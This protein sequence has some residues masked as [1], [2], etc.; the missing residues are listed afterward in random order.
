M[1]T[2][3][4]PKKPWTKGHVSVSYTQDVSFDSITAQEIG[5]LFT[6]IGTVS[7]TLFDVTKAQGTTIILSETGKTATAHILPRFEKDGL[8]FNWEPKNI[9]N[10]EG[11]AQQ[12]RD[13]FLAYEKPVQKAPEK[14]AQ[15]EQKE[16]PEPQEKKVPVQK[17]KEEKPK[18]PINF[19]FDHLKRIG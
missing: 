4:I 14:P 7:R 3:S 1:F 15:P 19:L 9:E 18:K 6:N 17:P 5:L 12:L 8:Q 13:A 10:M 16:E 11:V 2:L